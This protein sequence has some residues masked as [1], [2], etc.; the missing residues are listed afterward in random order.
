MP[1]ANPPGATP[2]DGPQI[3][4]PSGVIGRASTTPSM[5]IVDDDAMA[6]ARVPT[7]LSV[8][9]EGTLSEPNVNTAMLLLVCRYATALCTSRILGS[10]VVAG[11]ITAAPLVISPVSTSKTVSPGGAPSPASWNASVKAASPTPLKSATG[12]PPLGVKPT[13]GP[14]A[15]LHPVDAHWPSSPNGASPSP[16]LASL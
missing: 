15:P 1:P 9:P 6:T 14:W 5:V 3:S 11:R 12:M 10:P 2:C 7:S 16:T 8:V 13:H 4:V